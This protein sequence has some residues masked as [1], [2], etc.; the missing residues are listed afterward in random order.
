[1]SVEC[2]LLFVIDMMPCGMVRVRWCDIVLVAHMSTEVK[3]DNKTKVYMSISN[4][5]LVT[6]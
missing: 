5:Y 3:T 6:L 2:S 1:M 4:G